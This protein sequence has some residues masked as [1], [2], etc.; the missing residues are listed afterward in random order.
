[1][2]ITCWLKMAILG[3]GFLE[4]VMKMLQRMKKKKVNFMQLTSYIKTKA[5]GFEITTG[6]RTMP[7]QTLVLP[8]ILTG[9]IKFDSVA[10]NKVQKKKTH[11][12]LGASTDERR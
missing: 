4:K 3:F 6:Q 11:L 9:H 2:Y 7:G 12:P 10:I 5:T 8:V 1:M